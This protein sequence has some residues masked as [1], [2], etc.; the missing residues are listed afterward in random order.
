[1]L[2]RSWPGEVAV[3]GYT[4]ASR[5]DSMVSRSSVSEG[6]F[7]TVGT[8]MIGGR[9]FNSHDT[10]SSP[11]VAIVSQSMARKFF[12]GTNPVGRYFRMRDGSAITE[13]VEI[14]GVVKDARYE[15]LRAEP[16]PFVFLPWSQGG[17]PGPLTSFELRGAGAP[18]AL[19]RGVKSAIGAVNRG[20]WMEFQTLAD[21]VGASISR[22]QLLARLAGF[23]GGLA[24]LLAAI[25]LYGVMSY[26]VAR[27]RN[28]IGIR[29]ALGAQRTRVVG[30]V[31]GETAV[32]AGAGLAIGLAATLPAAR[33]IASF[34]YGVK[35]NDPWTLSAACG[36]LA[37][38]SGAAAYL[39]ARR[40]SRVEPMAALRE[41]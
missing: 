10:A 19:S 2:F 23:F 13:P 41:E 33:L 8:P 7:E 35:A 32:L 18:M 4:P 37:M 34:L 11:K 12:H 26:T 9:D 16:A 30:A 39:P 25:G 22:E 6:Y 38:A 14:V 20:V 15:S 21:K 31:L 1:M 40:A 36:L 29:M 3:D 27:R 5:A 28:E 17:A 24:L